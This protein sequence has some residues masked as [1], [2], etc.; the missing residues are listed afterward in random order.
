MTAQ[1][2]SSLVLSKGIHT[3]Y[4][5]Q[6]P[7]KYVHVRWRIHPSGHQGELTEHGPGLLVS[8]IKETSCI[9]DEVRRGGLASGPGCSG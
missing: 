5:L 2:T 8:A 9:L 1:S 3:R 4:S 6:C 7:V